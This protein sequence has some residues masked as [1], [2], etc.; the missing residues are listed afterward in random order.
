MAVKSVCVWRN[1]NFENIYYTSSTY[2]LLYACSFSSISSYFFLPRLCFI[3]LRRLYPFD[4]SILCLHFMHI[5]RE[6]VF[7]L[8]VFL[9]YT[10]LKIY[11]TYV[12]KSICGRRHLHGVLI[13]V[14]FY[15]YYLFFYFLFYHVYSI[16]VI[17]VYMYVYCWIYEDTCHHIKSL[18][19]TY[20]MHE[21]I[22]IFIINY[23]LL[24]LSICA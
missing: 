19:S 11:R 22:V 10:T 1:I 5:I 17:C 23:L 3:F 4:H 6:C 7:V 13:F 15:I 12:N 2:S 18:I 8:R 20:I 16:R 21:T 14:L 24:S 9:Y